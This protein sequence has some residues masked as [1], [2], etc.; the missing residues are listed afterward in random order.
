MEIIKS[1]EATSF[2]DIFLAFNEAF[3][4]YEI[5]IN[6]EELQSMLLR[7]GFVPKLSFGA[8]ENDKLVAFTLNGIG[9]FNRIKTA[10]D[11]G[12]GT[13]KSHRGKGLATQI[14]EYAL[15]FLKQ[16][17]VMQ[18]LLEVLQH[19]T[20]AVSVY[21]KLGFM[22]SREF[23]YFKQSTED[24]KLGSKKP[25]IQFCLRETDL[26]RKD[27]MVLFWDFIPSWQNSFEAIT[28]KIEDFRILGAFD[29]DRLIGYGIMEPTSGDITQIAVDK[30]Y[31][32]KGV[33][34][35]ILK[36]LL[37]Y[38]NYNSVKAINT[39]VTCKAVTDFFEVRNILQRGKQ[40]EMILK[41]S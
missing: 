8:F 21:S 32:M 13:I 30:A 29:N 25:S 28:R 14:F 23:N 2:D 5:S 12:T 4:D 9:L 11:T 34:S 27:E 1:L 3:C 16:A 26:S 20:K 39:D 15:P 19:N 37:K 22:I 31:R 18:Y 35:S 17:D 10:Y 38:N 24:I 33:A 6:K 40:F 41:I 7:R 36:E